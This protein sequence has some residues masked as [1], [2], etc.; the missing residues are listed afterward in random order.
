MSLISIRKKIE[1]E[2]IHLPELKPLIGQT[3]EIT[4][5]AA[6]AETTDWDAAFQAVAELETYDFDAW[7]AQREYD[8]LHADDHVK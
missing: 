6:T 1:S 8:R 3:V 2:T 4:V 5:R 7:R